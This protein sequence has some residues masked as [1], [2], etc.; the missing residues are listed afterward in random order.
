MLNLY[1]EA[2]A[3]R[4][5]PSSLQTGTKT[6]K[7]CQLRY[8]GGKKKRTWFFRFEGQL[9]KSATWSITAAKRHLI[10]CAFSVKTFDLSYG[11]GSFY[12]LYPIFCE[13]ETTIIQQ[14][15]LNH[16]KRM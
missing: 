6:Y 13:K 15:G 10:M 9:T 4:Q 16:L 3:F 8:T 7:I 1:E 11:F 2:H 5:K 12:I 14:T